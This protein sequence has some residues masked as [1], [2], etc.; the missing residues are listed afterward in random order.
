MCRKLCTLCTHTLIRS[1]KLKQAQRNSFLFVAWCS[2]TNTSHHHA[3]HHQWFS[4]E[5]FFCIEKGV[6]LWWPNMSMST[7]HLLYQ[8]R[9]FWYK[10]P[11]TKYFWDE[12]QTTKFWSKYHEPIFS[13]VL[14]QKAEQCHFV[15]LT[16]KALGY[17][18]TKPHIC[19]WMWPKV[20]GQFFSFLGHL[21]LCQ[22]Y[23][24]EKS[25]S[26]WQ[27]HQSKVNMSILWITSKVPPA[28]DKMFCVES[29]SCF[30][31]WNEWLEWGAA[32][33]KSLCFHSY[34]TICKCM[35]L[36]DLLSDRLLISQR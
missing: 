4:A 3:H 33:L 25:F 6:H 5:G 1:H 24:R 21:V 11:H 30:V 29:F 15:I 19:A 13:L 35:C 8:Q 34:Q 36:L 14:H 12:E 27:G 7:Q 28:L 16:C 17:R 23:P 18:P 31:H 2:T 10:Q 9:P 26:R 32:R 20:H 22:A